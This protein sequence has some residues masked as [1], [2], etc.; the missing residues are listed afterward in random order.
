MAQDR[1][2]VTVHYRKF[3]PGP[4]FRRSLQEMVQQSMN[5]TFDQRRVRD[6]YQSRVLSS[7]DD[8]Y[9]A[10]IYV[11]TSPDGESVVFGDVIHFTKGHLQALLEGTA[12]DVASLPVR[13]MPAP[14]QNEYVHSQMFWMIKNDHVFVIQSLSLRTA[15]LEQYLAW[16]LQQR[17]PQAFSDPI[18]LVAQFDA[19]A[20]GGDLNDIQEIIVGGVATAPP[21]EEAEPER[22]AAEVVETVREVTSHGEV[23]TARRTGWAQAKEILQTLLGGDAQVAESVLQAVPAEAEL[24][25]E[26]H[27]GYKTRKRQIDRTSLRQLETGLR[28][29]EDSELTVRGKDG[30][31]TPAGAIRLQHKASILLTKMQDGDVQVIGSLLDPTDVLR[32]MWEAYTTMSANGKLT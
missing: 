17:L 2:P 31:K 19:D 30:V 12:N 7:G 26:V 13:Q 18:V 3:A 22:Q 15:D 25:V 14:A 8:N 29:L 11:E 21:L 6:R 1:K 16:L 5:A 24:R 9:F 28:N 10:N 32:A 20:V 4:G 23:G 27:I